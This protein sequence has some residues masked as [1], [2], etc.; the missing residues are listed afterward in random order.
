M[1]KLDAGEETDTLCMKAKTHS[2]KTAT[3]KDFAFLKKQF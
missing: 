2:S 1:A 3:S